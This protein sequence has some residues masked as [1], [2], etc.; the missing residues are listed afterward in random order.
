[1]ELILAFIVAHMI[2]KARGDTAALSTDPPANAGRMTRWARRTIDDAVNQPPRRPRRPR[3]GAAGI[4]DRFANWRDRTAARLQGRAERQWDR[5]EHDQRNRRRLHGGDDPRSWWRRTRD[6][7]R[8]CPKCG[9]GGIT[10]HRG[11]CT[12]T[13]CRC[14]HQVEPHWG[15]TPRPATPDPDT[16]PTPTGSDGPAAST[17]PTAPAP[18]DPATPHAPHTT[19]ERTHPMTA[20]TSPSAPVSPMS[21]APVSPGATRP[22][23][24]GGAAS[25]NNLPPLDAS[26]IRLSDARAHFNAYAANVT[27]I[28]EGL[29]SREVDAQTT[30]KIADLAAQ[31]RSLVAD[32]N[33]EYGAVEQAVNDSRHVAQRDAY[34]HR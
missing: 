14:R 5:I 10:G 28:S 4:A 26:D 23:A 2:M 7:A 11:D 12:C 29:R 22:A 33:R 18:T 8:T 21:P 31:F 3:P 1:M 16:T 32:I 15:A 34:R 25:T 13:A 19:D 20:P 9:H 6:Q 17:D 30:G 27:L 24:T